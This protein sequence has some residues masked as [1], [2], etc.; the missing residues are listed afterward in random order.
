[1]QLVALVTGAVWYATGYLYSR[2]T[3]AEHSILALQQQGPACPWRLAAAADKQIQ[4]LSVVLQAVS[5]CR[6]FTSCLGLSDMPLATHI[7]Y[8]QPRSTRFL[9]CSSRGLHAHGVQMQL[10]KS[11]SSDCRWCCRQYLVAA[12]S[13]A[14]WGCLICPYPLPQRIYRR[15]AL[16]SRTHRR[17]IF[18]GPSVN[19]GERPSQSYGSHGMPRAAAAGHQPLLLSWGDLLWL[20]PICNERGAFRLWHVLFVL[21]WGHGTPGI[22]PGVGRGTDW[23]PGQSSPSAGPQPGKGGCQRQRTR[24]QGASGRHTTGPRQLK[25]FV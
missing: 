5:R 13:L 9:P 19:R 12:G 25:T 7:A 1:M 20:R 24:P 2:Y 15:R 10:L 3:A 4:R 16:D 14:A 18:W 11:K 17:G 22:A 23:A 6:W 21:K 8:I